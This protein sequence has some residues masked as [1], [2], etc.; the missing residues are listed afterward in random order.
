MTKGR[1]ILKNIFEVIGFVTCIN[2]FSW[3]LDCV[4][5]V[6]EI[7]NEVKITLLHSVPCPIATFHLSFMPQHPTHSSHSSYNKV[8]PRT[9]VGCSHAMINVKAKTACDKL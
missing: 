4:S 2:Y 1:G 9:A 6:D 8:D 3:G 7:T 5:S